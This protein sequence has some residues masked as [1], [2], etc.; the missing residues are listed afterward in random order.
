M[1]WD[2]R[3][4][5]RS[6][7][8]APV[9]R[10]GSLFRSYTDWPL[11]ECLQ[12]LL[13]RE[14]V[15]TAAG[16]PLRLVADPTSEPY[17]LCVHERGEMHFRERD[18]HDFFNV[19]AWLTY[20]QTKAALNDAQSAALKERPCASDGRSQRGRR[21]DALTLFDENGAVVVAS[22]PTLLEDLRCFRWKRLFVERRSDVNAAMGMFV[23]G[24]AL[25][26]KALSPYVGMTA[27]SMLFKVAP[28]LLAQ[29]VDAQIRALDSQI[30]E[31]ITTL[32][33]P[34]MLSPL[35]VLGVPGWWRDNEDPRFYD[36]AEYFRGGRH[37][38][39]FRNVFQ[40]NPRSVL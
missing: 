18:W 3:F 9:A 2:P 11:R 38:A 24:H 39:L 20:P 27:H 13:S 25:L 35:P 5:E 28:G 12:E 22:D 7:M 37:K 15:T 16:I 36:K 1:E 30:A 29:D 31:A 21:R 10:R 4:T 26:A 19:L 8:F 40:A 32:A 14:R 6:P 23:F 34:A 33:A 17:E